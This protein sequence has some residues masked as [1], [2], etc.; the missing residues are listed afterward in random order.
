[1]AGRVLALAGGLL[2]LILLASWQGL[3][4]P[5]PAPAASP[6]DVFSAE[7]AA[8]VLRDLYTGLES[9]PVGSPE[10]RLLRDRIVEHL[11]GLGY[12]PEIQR[13]LACREPR[14]SCAVVENILARLE[15]S[16][17][18][19]AVM[20]ST[21]YDSV[22][23]GPGVSDAGVSVAA[24]LEIARVL[25]DAPRPGNP[26]IFFIGDGEEAGL[27]GAR[28]FVGHHRW[29]PHVGVII[30][31]EARGTAGRSWMFET[32]DGGGWLVGAYARSVPHP[33][34]ASVAYAIYRRLP[35]DTDLTVY[36]AH[37]LH[38]VGFAFIDRSQQYHTSLDNL[39]NLSL[40]SL[41]QQ[42]GNTLALAVELAGMDLEAP[43]AGEAVFL[44][45][46]GRVALH[47]PA[48][49]APWMAGTGLL[50]GL[51]VCGG[52]ILKG[53]A[54]P[55]ALLAGAGAWAGSALGGAAAGLGA[56]GILDASG[57]FPGAYPAH[58][59]AHVGAAWAAGCLPAL[60]LYGVFCRRAGVW[61][62]LGGSLLAWSLL[63]V[64]LT[65]VDPALSY[66]SAGPALLAGAGALVATLRRSHGRLPVTALLLL[67]ASGAP[68]LAQLVLVLFGAMGRTA[69]PAISVLV[70]LMVSTVLPSLAGAGRQV[71]RGLPA[72]ALALLIAFTVAASILPPWTA[73]RPRRLSL[74]HHQDAGTGRAWWAFY[75]GRPLP[76][77]LLGAAGGE[78]RADRALPWWDRDEEVVA[79]PAHALEG[80]ETRVTGLEE[81]GTL[82]LHLRSTRGASLMDVVLPG[83]SRLTEVSYPGVGTSALGEGRPYSGGAWRSWRFRSIPPQGVTVRLD[84]GRGDSVEMWTMDRTRGLPGSA[85]ALL[86]ARPA[87]AVPSQTGDV[88]VVFRKER[89]PLA[90]G[91][92]GVPADRSLPPSG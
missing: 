55:G 12:R 54:R 25:R 63:G 68:A 77:G 33:A 43:G 32:S 62:L 42:G 37:G 17:G 13:E 69:L 22:P 8:G 83:E 4:P 10:N 5:R 90:A 11:K 41:Q 71:R 21:H 57:A 60:L 66:M 75:G 80:P 67:P 48:V 59:W 6:R 20:L 16:P 23:A 58:S 19:P 1:M 88:T 44:D 91:R 36:K 76:A 65:A 50:L 28:A 35:T 78:V 46:F 7:R 39:A 70:A 89:I 64:G 3:Q 26:V 27:L 73:E 72:A 61:G 38:G 86:A 24:V 84:P 14:A 45:L 56:L 87:H 92:G 74:A 30:N 2:V 18:R 81:D 53:L 82:W 49:V 9:H 47:W 85:R 52:M 15:G 31:L 51:A 40:S 29:A 79:A 34:T